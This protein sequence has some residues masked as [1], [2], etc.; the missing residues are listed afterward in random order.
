MKQLVLQISIFSTILI[1]VLTLVIFYSAPKFAFCQECS[2]YMEAQQKNGHFNSTIAD[3]LKRKK[4]HNFEFTGNDKI[5]K[6][7]FEKYKNNVHLMMKLNDTT[8]VIRFKFNKTTN[9]QDFI[10]VFD[11]CFV[12]GADYSYNENDLWISNSSKSF[13]S[14]CSF[15]HYFLVIFLCSSFY[16]SN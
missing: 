12:E 10:N 8:K 11:V 13:E 2:V 3:I 4:L 16:F 14:C 7:T 6:I 15:L 1:I 5:D 9:Y